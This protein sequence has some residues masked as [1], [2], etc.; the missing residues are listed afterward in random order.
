M[1]NLKKVMAFFIEIG[2]VSD[3]VGRTKDWTQ[4]MQLMDEASALMSVEWKLVD[5]EARVAD[6]PA[7]VEFFK[8]KLD[9][10]D[11]GLEAKIESTVATVAAVAQTILVWVPKKDA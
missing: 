2:N 10:E 6:I 11:D 5:D 7:L 9:L 8:A 3:K 4:V 1:E